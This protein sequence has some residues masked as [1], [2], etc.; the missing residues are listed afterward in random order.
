MAH[1]GKDL[2]ADLYDLERVAKSDLPTVSS[3]YDDAISKCDGAQKVLD[4]MSKVPEQFVSEHGAVFENY[5]GAH[6][7]IID[8]LRQTRRNLDETAKAL[9]DA[10]QLYAETDHAAAT[11][12]GRLLDDRGEPKPE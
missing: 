7:A 4:G 3:A 10:A 12:L 8:V 5:S 11:E 1:T 9:H 2:G 6:N